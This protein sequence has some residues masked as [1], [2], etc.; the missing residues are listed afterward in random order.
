MPPSYRH[1]LALAAL[2]VAACGPKTTDGTR[3]TTVT[4]TTTTVIEAPPPPPRPADPLP[5]DALV[6]YNVDLVNSYRT[7]AGRAALLYDAKISAFALDGSKQLANDHKAHAH[8]AAQSGGAPGFG[9]HSAEN[10]GD[11]SGVPPMDADAIASGKKQIAAL[12][13]I[14]MAEGPGGGHYENIL[15]AKYRRIG[16][17]LYSPG[18]RLFLTNDFSD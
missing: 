14:M 15:S 2:F 18:G 4:T 6:K 1:A 11:P 12:M 10:Q 13:E 8:F 16:V 7:K 5:A 9:T 17:G 3:T